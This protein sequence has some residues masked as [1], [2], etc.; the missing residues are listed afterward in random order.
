M[1]TIKIKANDIL[2]IIDSCYFFRDYLNEFKDN[3]I[4]NVSIIDK[5]RINGY[6]TYKQIK[7]FIRD[8][9]FVNN[10]TE[11]DFFK[12]SDYI[13][14]NPDILRYYINEYYEYNKQGFF[15]SFII[16]NQFNYKE[17]GEL[18]N[19]A[20]AK[21]S[22]NKRNRFLNELNHLIWLFVCYCFNNYQNEI[23]RTLDMSKEF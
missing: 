20:L 1:N 15:K 11:E 17:L 16:N 8:D 5:A 6:F 4:T 13:Q 2:E 22:F 12:I 21:F 7:D 19:K 23:E 9:Y 14:N 10:C 3:H 18:Y